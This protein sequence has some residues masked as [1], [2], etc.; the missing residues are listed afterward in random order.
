[1]GKSKNS[2]ISGVFG[3]G[4]DNPSKKQTN[5]FCNGVLTFCNAVAFERSDTR[6]GK[7]LIAPFGDW[8]NGQYIQRIDNIAAENLKRNMNRVWTRIKNKFGN[9]CPVFYEHPDM[10]DAKELPDIADKTPYGKV[11]S[12]EILPNGIY[13][14]IE[15]LEGFDE[16]PRSLQISPRWNSDFI[17]GNIARPARLLSLGLTRTPLIK[18]TDFVNSNQ[19][20]E[21]EM[22]MDKELLK[23]LGYSDEDAQKIIDNTSDAPTDVLDRIKKSLGEKLSL[24]NDCAAAKKEAEETKVQLA[25]SRAALK[26]SQ[27]HRAT[28]I[29]A[30]AVRSGKIIEAQRES[31]VRILANSENFEEEAQK[32]EGQKPIVKTKSE[33]DGIEKTEKERLFGQQKAQAEFAKLV[34]EK[35]E[36]GME[37]G[38][39]WNAAKTEKPEI[40]KAAY[41][42][43]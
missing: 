39:A 31:A 34:S 18:D 16:L 27:T 38:E 32:L 9:A 42:N 14:E 41:P 15:W 25:N 24:A 5:G 22:T 30:N 35:Q 33:T 4:A 8:K 7:Y 2:A 37:Y 1:M 26:E 12:L 36:Q 20:K 28:L 19:T 40:F 6:R 13:A 21:T 43:E 23:L 3:V 11:C 29:V 17:A 10:E